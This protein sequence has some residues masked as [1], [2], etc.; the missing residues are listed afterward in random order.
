MAYLCDSLK[1][2]NFHVF[3]MSQVTDKY[4][5]KHS[6]IY[7]KIFRKLPSPVSIFGKLYLGSKN[8]S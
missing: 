6:Y 7:L 3:E 8:I 1:E 2:Y 4:L 5:Q